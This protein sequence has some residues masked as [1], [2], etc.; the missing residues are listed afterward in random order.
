[1]IGEAGRMTD[2]IGAPG[3]LDFE[4]IYDVVDLVYQAIERPE[5]LATAL[6]ALTRR[7]GASHALLIAT[8]PSGSAA[9]RRLVAEGHADPR[10][11]GSPV[12]STPSGGFRVVGPTRTVPIGGG[13][14][15]VLDVG[16]LA[17]PALAALLRVTPHLA[18]A[19]RLAER[20]GV[21]HPGGAATV[22][23]A[24]D[25][26]A[27]GV[28]LL[29]ADGLVL[30]VNGAARAVVSSSSLVGLR[31]GRL[32]PTQ[33][34]QRTLFETLVERVSAPPTAQRSSAGGRLELHAPG[35]ATVELVVAPWHGHLERGEAHC[36]VLISSPGTVPGPD[37]IFRAVHG[38][39]SEESAVAGHLV[40]G[41]DPAAAM[42]ELHPELIKKVQERVFRRLGTT[43][44]GDL[45]RLLLRPPGVLF[46]PHEE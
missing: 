28:A 11:P 20:L 40:A 18:R 41:R 7:M 29:A 10:R 22:E 17:P 36:A 23:P 37:E 15:L 39:S 31:E 30:A 43:R 6:G 46:E 27:I 38:L 24:L 21:P 19:L 8:P 16:E 4:G 34:V 44:Q 25:R 1:M 14:E 35:R 13:Y 5:K 9:P 3:P 33:A 32:L 2:P 26:L 12:E 45:V 42:S